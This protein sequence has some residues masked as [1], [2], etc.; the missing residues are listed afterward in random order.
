MFKTLKSIL[1]SAAVFATSLIVPF[2]GAN[3]VASAQSSPFAGMN[4]RCWYAQ[5]YDAL[6]TI[7][8][9]GFTSINL[10]W[11]TDLSPDLLDKFLTKCSGLGFTTTVT[12]WDAYGKSDIS[13]LQKCADYWCLTD[14][15]TVMRNH[16]SV[17][18][19]IA[20]GWDP[21][22]IA[23]WQNG[24]ETV[25][26]KICSSYRGKIGV[27][28]PVYVTD[29]KEVTE[30]NATAAKPRVTQFDFDMLA[31]GWEKELGIMSEIRNEGLTPVCTVCKSATT[32]DTQVKDDGTV[33][34]TTTTQAGGRTIITT[35]TINPDGTT[36]TTT[37][38]AKSV[39]SSGTG[40]GIVI[41]PFSW[42]SDEKLNMTADWKN[43]SELGK[44]IASYFFS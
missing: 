6:G 27:S 16:S 36:H 3:M 29:P 43:Y 14:V 19:E 38:Q 26:P 35:T 12:L 40:S 34:T 30:L 1:T 4:L 8:A 11:R 37:T 23:L 41:A 24:Y 33:I 5:A 31:V 42:N 9:D 18:L 21:G 39:I 17:T 7:K 20:A 13:A 28:V 22:S 32:T 15:A 25:L 10:D 44:E 2:A